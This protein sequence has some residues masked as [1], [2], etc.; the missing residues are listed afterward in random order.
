MTYRRQK[1]GLLALLSI[2]LVSGF[3]STS[4]AGYFVSVNSMRE[5]IVSSA[6]PLTGDTV[7]SEIQRDLLRPVFISSLMANDTFLK[8]WIASGELDEGQISKYLGEIKKEYETYSSFLVSE[9]TRRYYYG[10]GILKEVQ[11]SEPR[12]A[13]YF[14]IRTLEAEYET[15]VD[16]DMANEDNLTVFV[17]HK[18]HDASGAYL[19]ATGVGLTI[20]SIGEMVAR[21]RQTYGHHIYFV[22]PQ[23]DFVLRG[24]EIP[25]H[26]SNLRELEGF[27]EAAADLL[28]TSMSQIRIER[29]SGLVHINSRF[30][31]E[32]N[33]HLIIEQAEGPLTQRNYEALLVNLTICASITLII[34]GL[35]YIS[36][37]AYQRRIDKI[38]DEERKL[39]KEVNTLSGLLPICAS[40]KSIRGEEGYWKQVEE[41]V[42][43]HT[44]AEFSHGICPKCMDILYP[45]IKPPSEADS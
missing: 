5:H 42:S 18:I 35:T 27:E 7:Y 32:L 30:I 15:N 34:L 25:Q 43:E 3:L 36:I 45:E 20:D 23:G 29:P 39:R 14:R 41:Y 38:F 33:W 10:G 16:P 17:N 4:L 24:A 40:C 21:Y 9:K 28:S 44:E 11:E 1:F 19:G 8:D 37:G 6:L 13:W 12:D 31:P 26:I 22:N 2:L